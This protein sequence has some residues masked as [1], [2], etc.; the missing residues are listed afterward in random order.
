MVSI[1]KIREII[2]NGDYC[3]GEM[4][5]EFGDRLCYTFEGKN[6]DIYL[7]KCFGQDQPTNE[8][9]LETV[10]SAGIEVSRGEAEDIDE[11]A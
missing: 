3:G 7:S 6:W 11:V 2:E 8:Q 5:Y 4:S 9:I 1:E 10:V